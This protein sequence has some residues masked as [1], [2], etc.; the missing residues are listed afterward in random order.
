MLYSDYLEDSEIEKFY[1][2]STDLFRRPPL[3]NALHIE[4][5]DFDKAE[6]PDDYTSANQEKLINE[7]YFDL[8]KSESEAEVH[9]Q[10]NGEINGNDD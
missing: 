8:I 4:L 2:D 7:F 5:D 1:T 10:T 9:G 6:I 3:L